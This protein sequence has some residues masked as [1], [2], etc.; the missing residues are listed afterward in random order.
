MAGVL[1]SRAA[2]FD[3]PAQALICAQWGVAVPPRSPFVGYLDPPAGTAVYRLVGVRRQLQRLT[4]R[5]PP[6][7][8]L[9]AAMSV[10]EEEATATELELRRALVAVARASTPA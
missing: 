6:P 1:L 7:P 10:L 4:A 9:L 5:C 3:Q 2:P 8:A